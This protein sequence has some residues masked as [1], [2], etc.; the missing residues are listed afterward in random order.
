MS[1]AALSGIRVIEL[2]QG[3]VGTSF[4]KQLADFGAEV[5]KIESRRRPDNHR[6]AFPERWN[7]SV[8]FAKHHRNKKDI[9]INLSTQEGVELAKRLIKISDIVIENL[10]LGVLKKWGLDY[11]NLK[12]IKPDIIDRKS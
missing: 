3:A 1:E 11:P 2:C 6:G 10:S 9:T 12:K 7:S 5:I 8:T 4:C